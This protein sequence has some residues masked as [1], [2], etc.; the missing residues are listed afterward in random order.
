MSIRYEAFHS[1]K[2]A[3]SKTNSTLVAVSK[4]QPP[5][6][7][8]ELYRAGQIDFGENRVQE[9][10][11]KHDILPDEIQWHLIGH[12]Q[13]NKVKYIIPWIHMIHSGDRFKVLKEIDKE[14]KKRETKTA[15]LLQIK[16]AEEESKFGFEF[17]QLSELHESGSIQALENTSI[18]GVMGMATFTD[19]EQQVRNEFRKLKSYFDWLKEKFYKTNEGFKVISMGMSGDYRIALEEG[20]NMVRIGS[21]I[22]GPR[23]V[24]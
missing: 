9:L 20:S 12:L 14:S 22:F 2:T 23:Q 19:N 17:E 7:I 16:I 11:D 3:V 4:T 5:E 13:T 6:L 1:L 8:E 10:T 24:K 18:Q 15:V 21:L